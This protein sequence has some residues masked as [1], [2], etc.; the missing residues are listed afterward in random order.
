MQKE[1]RTVQ[2]PTFASPMFTVPVLADVHADL[3]F[4]GEGTDVYR[5]HCIPPPLHLPKTPLS[6]SN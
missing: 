3:H 4:L 1:Q 2:K 6:E 5:L